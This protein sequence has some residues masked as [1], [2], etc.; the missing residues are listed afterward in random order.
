MGWRYGSWAGGA[1]LGL[2]VRLEAWRHD[3]C[4]G[5]NCR[6]QEPL[7]SG[8]SNGVATRCRLNEYMLVDEPGIDTEIA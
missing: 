2:E 8:N 3:S 6:L 7:I 5:K 1:A 4:T